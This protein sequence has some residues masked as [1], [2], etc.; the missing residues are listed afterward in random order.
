MSVQYQAVGWNR[1]KRIYDGVLATSVVAYL[2]IFV[3]VGSLIHPQATIETLLIRAFGTG[4]LREFPARLH[5]I[6]PG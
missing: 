5:E 1:Q 4:A 2:A 3:G 6:T